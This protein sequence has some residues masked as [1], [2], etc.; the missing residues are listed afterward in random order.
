MHVVVFDIGL[1]NGTVTKKITY[2]FSGKYFANFDAR[3]KDAAKILFVD[4]KS[5]IELLYNYDN[6]MRLSVN[7]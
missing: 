7:D 3:L 4:L 1:E 5:S 6:A 2:K